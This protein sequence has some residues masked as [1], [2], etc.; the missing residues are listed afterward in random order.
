MQDLLLSREFPLHLLE[1]SGLA[2]GERSVVR[3]VSRVDDHD[4]HVKLS[5]L[6]SHHLRQR[7]QGNLNKTMSDRLLV[8]VVVV[9]VVVVTDLAGRV[10]PEG[11][12]R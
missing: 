11:W 9:V 6:C 10:G 4:L 8:M 2:G 5:Q 1:M 3:G 12:E 7:Q